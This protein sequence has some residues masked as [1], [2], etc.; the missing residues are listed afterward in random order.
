MNL[1]F[2]HGPPAA[3]KRTVGEAIVELVGGRLFDN[4]VAIDF[5]RTVLDFDAPGFWKLVHSARMLAIDTAAAHGET[6]LVATFCYSHPDDLPLL[7]NFEE[8][9]ARHG[10]ALLPAFLSCS[11]TTLE[12]RVLSAERTQRRK[13]S[14]RES[15]ATCLARWNFVPVPRTRCLTVDIEQ[16][17]AREAAQWIVHQLRLQ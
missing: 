2:L 3:G 12:E 9:L 5:A 7:E 4:H 13:I 8:V 6:L 15:L 11:R 17:S 14:S 10:G 1:V 16:S